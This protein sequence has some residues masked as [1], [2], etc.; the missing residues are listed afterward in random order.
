MPV[1][2]VI[3]PVPARRTQ[4]DDVS[5]GECRHAVLGAQDEPAGVVDVDRL[6]VQG[7]VARQLD[8]YLPAEGAAD[9]PVGVQQPG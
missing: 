2:V 4:V 7:A 3:V 1:T 5:G 6:P 9:R 8:P